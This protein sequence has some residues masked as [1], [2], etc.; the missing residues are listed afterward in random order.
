MAARPC[1][2]SA[3][4]QLMSVHWW[5]AV[6]IIVFDRPPYSVAMESGEGQLAKDSGSFP[7][8]AIGQLYKIINYL[9]NNEIYVVGSAH[10]TN[11][12]TRRISFNRLVRESV[13][14]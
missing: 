8:L 14:L 1:C 12:S 10:P 2:N 13:A 4:Q 3:F 7:A 5:M 11:E 9:S 6:Y